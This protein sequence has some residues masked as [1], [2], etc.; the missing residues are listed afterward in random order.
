MSSE[1]V[2]LAA[3]I[4]AELGQA[5]LRGMA[6]GGASDGNDTAGAGCPTLDG[7]GAVGSGAHADSEHVDVTQMVPRSRLLAGLIS[8]TCQ[9]SPPPAAPGDTRL[10]PRGG[11]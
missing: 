1:L 6:V 8:R 3:E 7:L 5:P 11:P 9:A 4:A 2:Q 10:T